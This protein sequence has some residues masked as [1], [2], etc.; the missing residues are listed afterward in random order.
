MTKYL[1][2]K[3]Y[4]TLISQKDNLNFWVGCAKESMHNIG[5]SFVITKKSFFSF[6]KNK[7][8]GGLKN[9]GIKRT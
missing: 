4:K 5:V 6:F 3:E 8:M 9:E 2:W 7:I 1:N